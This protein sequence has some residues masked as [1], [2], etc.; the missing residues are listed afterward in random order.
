MCR[1]P[2]TFLELLPLA[3]LHPFCRLHCGT[4]QQRI[5]TEKKNHTF[6]FFFFLGNA[7]QLLKNGLSIS[8]CESSDV[9]EDHLSRIFTITKNLWYWKKRLQ[10]IIQFWRHIFAWRFYAFIIHAQLS[11]Y[12]NGINAI[13][14]INLPLSSQTK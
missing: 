2:Y 4:R 6:F 5:F 12:Q 3:S 14:F 11:S 7:I 8:Y 13:C 9:L 1:I 10:F